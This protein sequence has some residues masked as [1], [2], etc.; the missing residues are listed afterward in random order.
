MQS[1][2][3]IGSGIAGL[4]C[5]HFLQRDYDITVFEQN[6]YIGGH[7]NTV[8]VDEQGRP[9]PVDTGFMVYNEVTYPNLT[10][11]FRE[12]KVET[13]PT[14]MSFSVQQVPLELEYCG[15]SFSQLFAQRRNLLN[16]RFIRMLG[17]VDRFNRQAAGAL[18]NPRWAA[19]T[20]REYV[21][22]RG[23]GEDFLDL[24]LVPMSAAVW[25]ASQES[26]LDFPA[27]TLLRFFHN[28]GFLGMHTQH[29]WRTV[30][31]GAQSYVQRLIAPFVRRILT[32]QPVTGVVRQHSQI[33]VVTSNGWVRAFD[34]VILACH[35]D[36]ALR[37]LEDPDPEQARL[38]G[39]F[40]YQ[41]NRATLHTDS[42][43]MPKSRRAWASWNYRMDT[44]Q[45]SGASTIYWMNRLQNLRSQ[46]QYFVS[47]N[48]PGR[49]DPAKILRQIQYH[50]P[51][52]DLAAVKAQSELPQLN[53]VSPEQTVYFCG[54]YFK[55]GFHE[56]ALNSALDLCSS[57]LR[58]P[59][60][61]AA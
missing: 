50:H 18:D 7:T 56:D 12:L 35:A 44:M 48:D 45:P 1:L 3:I 43:V 60:W 28:H 29:P 10:R 42:S 22:A 25:S 17:Q 34:K 31:G 47:I 52:F 53:R 14:C 38:L 32:G 49:I 30:E 59:L 58:R 5:A 33:R 21:E 54:S 20:L 51:L 57:L 15:S 26:M 27:Q 37:L 55:Y 23:Y 40:S 19:A 13:K 41:S 8:V 61:K 2:A 46:Q 9:I 6:N 16:P 24:Y 11:L 36:Q 4:G 39:R